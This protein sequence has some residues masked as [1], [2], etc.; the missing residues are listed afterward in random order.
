[1]ATFFFAGGFILHE[2]FFLHGFGWGVA[3]ARWL[4]WR[5]AGAGGSA[6][7]VGFGVFG[8]RWCLF[9][10]RSRSGSCVAAEFFCSRSKHSN[11][12]LIWPVSGRFD[13]SGCCFI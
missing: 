8:Q 5:C 12:A 3:R 4:A 6:F 7:G 9:L 13:C 2:V 1:V 10:R 11:L